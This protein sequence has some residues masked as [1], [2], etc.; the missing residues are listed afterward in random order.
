M[1][2]IIQEYKER[3]KNIDYWE[4]RRVKRLSFLREYEGHSYLTEFNISAIKMVLAMLLFIYVYGKAYHSLFLGEFEIYRADT[5]WFLWPLS[6]YFLY[7]IFDYFNDLKRYVESFLNDRLGHRP[8]LETKLILED[9]RSTE[10]KVFRRIEEPTE[11]RFQEYFK[12]RREKCEIKLFD[13]LKRAQKTKKNMIRKF[14]KKEERSKDLKERLKHAREVHKD[15]NR[16]CAEVIEYSQPSRDLPYIVPEWKKLRE[17]KD[18]I[19]GLRN[20]REFRNIVLA[21]AKKDFEK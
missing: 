5:T 19:W 20:P 6:I 2:K 16:L 9:I 4:L 13:S 17:Y 18:S 1:S 14:N 3:I 8:S 7:K 15:F 10:R 21:N 12:I 11:T